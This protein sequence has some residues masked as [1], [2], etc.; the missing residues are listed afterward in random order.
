MIIIFQ[1]RG[2]C[3]KS[4]KNKSRLFQRNDGAMRR[5]KDEEEGTAGLMNVTIVLL[6]LWD[7]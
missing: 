4:I 7:R 2:T 6:G 5:R 3:D 1:M